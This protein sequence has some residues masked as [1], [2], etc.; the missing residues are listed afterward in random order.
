MD[1]CQNIYKSSRSHAGFTQESAA[2]FLHIAPRTLGSYETGAAQVP[3]EIAD[4]MIE[5]YKDERLGYL[6]LMSNPVARRYLPEIDQ[7]S[8]SQA[9]LYLICTSS[10]YQAL[11][12][13]MMMM[14][15]DGK[16][17]GAEESDW[18]SVR[19]AIDKLIEAAFV[20][21]FAKAD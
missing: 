17:E 19:C 18:K 3:D 6:H 14:C 21:K 10:N 8:L 9:A 13:K 7:K 2:D 4:K 5:L 12:A 1:T 11:Q 15:S 16:I 20:M